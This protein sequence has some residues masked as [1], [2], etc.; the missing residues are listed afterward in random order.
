[1]PD[2]ELSLNFVI[3]IIISIFCFIIVMYAAS[4]Y[5]GVSPKDI[6]HLIPE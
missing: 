4:K 5:L 3:T 1:M 2:S 6:T